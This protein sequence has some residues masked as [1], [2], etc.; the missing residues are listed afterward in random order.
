MKVGHHSMTW[1]G[2]WRKHEEPFDLECCLREI[3]EAGYEGV[4]LSAQ[5]DAAETKRLLEEH[6]L[7]LGAVGVS[8]TANPWPP[9]TE[10]YRRGLDFA[11][12]M[13]V[14]T[15]SVCGGFLGEKRRNTFDS[16][17]ALFAEN[18]NAAAEYASQYGQTL[19]YHQHIGCIVETIE[20]VDRL[21]AHGPDVQLCVDT[22]HLAGVR[23]DPVELIR[24]Y[25]D[26]IAYTHVKDWDTEQKC[27]ME[28]GEGCLR[29]RFP[30]I[31]G[32]L[33]D[34]GFDGWLMVERDATPIPPA[35]SASI[36]SKF[37]R[38]LG[39]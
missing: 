36:S 20:E 4:E 38:T 10:Q 13:G 23:S 30:A 28:V 37:L 29:E 2:W 35:E 24:R 27:F 21:F 3:R 6:G 39:F 11:A 31:I 26:R 16:D 9:N 1:K 22:G 18:L 32:A 19:A 5:D 7:E 8:V 34:V 15:I 14:T 33:K 12:E 17:Y 25:P